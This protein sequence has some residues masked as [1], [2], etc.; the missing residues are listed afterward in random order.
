MCRQVQILIMSHWIL[1][2][3]QNSQRLL[4]NGSVRF[5]AVPFFI[6]MSLIGRV[7]LNIRSSIS[8]HSLLFTA[9]PIQEV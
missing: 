1:W 7:L 8:I 6:W 9:F 5:A 2:H 4:Q 3:N